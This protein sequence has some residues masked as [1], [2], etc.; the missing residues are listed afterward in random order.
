MENMN[1]ILSQIEEI[2]NKLRNL[3]E[4]LKSITVENNDENNIVTTIVD[5]TGKIT[6]FKFNLEVIDSIDHKD[7]ITALVN[8]ANNAVAK[9]KQ[10]EKDKKKAI[11][12]NVNIPDVPGLF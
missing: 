5:G 12:G 2:K 7:F 10:L 8:S 3:Q 6:D 9:A 4:E 11:V 1:N